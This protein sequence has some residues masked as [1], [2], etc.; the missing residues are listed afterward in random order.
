MVMDK[1][2]LAQRLKQYTTDQNTEP[3]HTQAHTR[4]T[5]LHTDTPLHF[6]PK[7]ERAIFDR[8]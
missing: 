8:L 2:K 3:V 5:H 1:K 4:M 7:K 6:Q